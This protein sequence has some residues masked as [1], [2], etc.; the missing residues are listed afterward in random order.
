[1]KLFG[2]ILIASASLLTGPAAEDP[3][4]V[5]VTNPVVITTD[6]INRLVAEARTNNPSLKAADSRV[7]SAALNAEAVRTWEDRGA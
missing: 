7:R 3:K 2:T 1:M 6:Y 5:Q 4:P